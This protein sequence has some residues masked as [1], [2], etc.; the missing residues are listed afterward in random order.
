LISNG[1]DRWNQITFKESVDK[2]LPNLDDIR[3]DIRRLAFRLNDGVSLLERTK[4]DAGNQ[5]QM[6][7]LVNLRNCARSAATIVSSASTIFEVNHPDC[8]SVWNGSEF[9]DCFP[10][11]QNEPMRRWMASMSIIGIEEEIEPNDGP[12]LGD[13]TGQP[14]ALPEVVDDEYGSQ[15]DSDSEEIEKI[16]ALFGRAKEKLAEQDFQSAERLFL[17]CL[18][19]TSTPGP[20]SNSSSTIRSTANAKSFSFLLDTYRRQENWDAAQALLMN[21][22]KSESQQSKAVN[23]NHHFLL[24]EILFT[25]RDLVASRKYGIKAYKG[26]RKLGVEGKKGVENSLQILIRICNAEEDFDEEDAYASIL[27]GI[28]RQQN[29]PAQPSSSTLS[30]SALSTSPEPVTI[31]QPIEV[32]RPNVLPRITSH[33]GIL[34]ADE[35]YY[36][37]DLEEAP[38]SEH[39]VNRGLEAATD[40]TSPK[41][42]N[43]T[44]CID[45]PSVPRSNVPASH[46][47]ALISPPSK[48]QIIL[49]EMEGGISPFSMGHI[50][51]GPSVL[52]LQDT[53]PQLPC[54]Q[55]RAA[56]EEPKATP[57]WPLP[58][59]STEGH[60]KPLNHRSML[61]L[62]GADTAK[63]FRSASRAEIVRPMSTSTLS[64]S[65]LSPS[66]YTVSHTFNCQL[67]LR[68]VSIYHEWK[69]KSAASGIHAN[70]FYLIYTSMPL[71]IF[72]ELTLFRILPHS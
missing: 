57:H 68:V 5:Y 56:S 16:E 25:K 45:S 14:Q 26:F 22:I 1:R 41:M 30:P 48:G 42:P 66:L 54:S 20:F 43:P 9:G 44:E 64:S 46:N 7:V 62:G 21:K 24:S 52:S 35:S 4:S 2:I 59:S 40:T 55:N 49:P 29:I 65:T 36:Q 61:D 28:L 67:T 8:M 37:K 50:F 11:E 60:T 72:P 51:S 58:D 17:N 32:N 34:V 38:K 69:S 63:G 27:F 10:N 12:Q 23:P 19:R 6:A 15:S 53:I 39:H 3:L 70:C 71:I 31:K 47:G 33:H 18:S 13:G